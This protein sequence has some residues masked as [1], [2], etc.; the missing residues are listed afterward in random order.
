MN[1]QPI[2]TAP[3]LSFYLD[4]WTDAL[5]YSKSFG[6]RQGAVCTMPDDTHWGRADGYSGD[7]DITHWM[8]LPEAPKETTNG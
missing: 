4:K 3:K 8:P 1:W 2:E 5:V 6:V 7:W